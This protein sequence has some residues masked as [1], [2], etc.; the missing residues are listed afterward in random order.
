MTKKRIDGGG[1]MSHKLGFTGKRGR[2]KQLGKVAKGK[3][4]KIGKAKRKTA[5]S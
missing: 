5:S 4:K 1:E 3:F 2:P